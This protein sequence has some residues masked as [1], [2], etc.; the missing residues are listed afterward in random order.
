MHSSSSASIGRNVGGVVYCARGVMFTQLLQHQVL[1]CKLA[2]NQEQEQLERM[3][4]RKE[5][6][7]SHSQ[8]SAFSA[9]RGAIQSIAS[10]LV[11]AI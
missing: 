3:Q 9:F 6:A 7:R 8:E 5:Q 10:I 1:G 11:Y 4:R 2:P